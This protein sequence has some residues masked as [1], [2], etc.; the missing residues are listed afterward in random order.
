M[1]SLFALHAFYYYIMP[2]ETIPNEYCI[3]RMG[4]TALAGFISIPA[5]FAHSIMGDRNL[6]FLDLKFFNFINTCL[7]RDVV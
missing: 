6:Y 5:F 4:A 3:K 7:S 1:F 2:S